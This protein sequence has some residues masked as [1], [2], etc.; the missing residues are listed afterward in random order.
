[1]FQIQKIFQVL[2]LLLKHSMK[3]RIDSPLELVRKV[4][5]SAIDHHQ[6]PRSTI[7]NQ[8]LPSCARHFHTIFGIVCVF[9]CLRHG[10]PTSEWRCAQSSQIMQLSAK[11]GST[12]LKLLVS[13]FTTMIHINDP[14]YS[15]PVFT[16]YAY[17]IK[18]SV[19]LR[20][21][22]HHTR[23]PTAQPDHSKEEWKISV[24]LS[25]YASISRPSK[26]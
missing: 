17:V 2:A 11:Q 13:V 5:H 20:S 25:A 15:T 7:T 6:R 23:E 18:S 21:R 8:V 19:R 3:G 10:G 1:M 16:E 9:H 24:F 4:A 26:L 12:G 14:E 22:H